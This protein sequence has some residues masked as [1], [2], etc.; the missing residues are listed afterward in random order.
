MKKQQHRQIKSF[1]AF[2]LLAV[3]ASLYLPGTLAY[4]VYLDRNFGEKIDCIS[5][6]SSFFGTTKLNP[7]STSNG[8]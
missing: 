4:Y 6:I 8:N 5:D 1:T 2:A 3:V 7:L